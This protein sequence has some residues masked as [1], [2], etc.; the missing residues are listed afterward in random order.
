MVL[1]ISYDLNGR[2]RPAAYER[3]RQYVER[4]AI[5]SVR[6]LYSQWLVET[7]AGPAAWSQ[8]L[9]DHGVTDPDDHLFICPVT[10]PYQ[11]WL[12]QACW[13]WLAART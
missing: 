7:N 13:V 2:E 9:R 1:L 11:G 6:P 12:P 3:M 10:H 8:A 4:H 5:S